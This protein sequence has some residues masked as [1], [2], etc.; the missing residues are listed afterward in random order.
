MPLDHEKDVTTF[1]FSVRSLI[2]DFQKLEVGITGEGYF[3]DSYTFVVPQTAL[4]LEKVTDVR[5]QLERLQARGV[6]T[7]ETD[8]PSK[9]EEDYFHSTRHARAT[10]LAAQISEF[11]E[12]SLDGER[13]IHL[14]ALNI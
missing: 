14:A 9:R 3:E 12:D 8:I 4:T 13:T 7:V 5:E 10:Y 6:L 1:S 11:D 2:S